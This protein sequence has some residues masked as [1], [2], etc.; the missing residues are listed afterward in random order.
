MSQGVKVGNMPAIEKSS[1]D[2]DSGRQS[3]RAGVQSVEVAAR[4]L[5]ALSRSPTAMTLT[6]I[7]AAAEMTMSKAHR[8]LVSLARCRLVTQD[9][10]TGRYDLGALSLGIGL[11]ALG[12]IDAVRVAT[13]ALLDLRD[14]VDETA[15]LAVWGEYGA[16][17]IRLEESAHPVR[18]NVRVGSVLPV[19]AS[20]IGQTFAAYLPESVVRDALERELAGASAP[21]WSGAFDREHFE[22]ILFDVRRRGLNRNVGI[23]YPG[24]SA[25]AA[26]VLDYQG[27][28]TAVIG[29]LGHQVSINVAWNGP[30]AKVLRD[31]TRE[32]S[33]RLGNPAD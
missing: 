32:V 28:I 12:R 19:A 13:E 10:K 18:M 9:E 29:V 22:G 26:P 25:M 30:V 20:A 8:Y 33:A 27:Q 23:Y 24:V 17:V 4:L 14:R 16:T 6:D 1:D 3:D 31:V 7:S 21:H 15:V 11:T 5:E 2:T